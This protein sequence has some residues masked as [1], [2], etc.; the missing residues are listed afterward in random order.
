MEFSDVRINLLI[1]IAIAI[2]VCIG[3]L[4]LSRIVEYAFKSRHKLVFK[5]VASIRQRVAFMYA[6]SKLSIGVVLISS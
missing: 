1:N 4:V 6:K 5:R 3:V 2:A